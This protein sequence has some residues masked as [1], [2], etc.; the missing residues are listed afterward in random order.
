MLP[1]TRDISRLRR[2]LDP[3][4]PGEAPGLLTM[5]ILAKNRKSSDGR[6]KIF[7]LLGMTETR[8]QTQN[9]NLAFEPHYDRSVEE[10]YTSFA[11]WAIEN[12]ENLDV[13]TQRNH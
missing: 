9:R 8:K 10:V 7:G 5:A 3:E 11:V 2:V 13:L 6:D 4:R 12:D 1:G